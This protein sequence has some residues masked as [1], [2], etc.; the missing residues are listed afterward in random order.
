MAAERLTVA[1]TGPTGDLG[2]AIVNAQERSRTV[3]IF[4]VTPPVRQRASSR[5]PSSML[6]TGSMTFFHDR[7][8]T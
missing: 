5:A 8:R 1:V 4:R 3:T 7:P 6:V 2:I